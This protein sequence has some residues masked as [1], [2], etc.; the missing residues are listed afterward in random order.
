MTG[1]RYRR[2][3]DDRADLT[4]RLWQP[5]PDE[6]WRALGSGTV[7][8]F[9]DYDGTLVPYAPRP[10]DAGPDEALLALLAELS[11]SPGLAIDIVSGR[12]RPDLERWFGHL[13]MA[14]WAEHAASCRD[15][16]GA[17][18]PRAAPAQTW[19]P[20]VQRVLE[21]FCAGVP[22]S[23]VET[24]DHGLA[25]HYR[26]A[27]VPPEEAHL[28]RLTQALGPLADREGLDVLEGDGVIEV[29]GAGTHKGRAVAARTFPPSA[30]RLVAIGDDRTDEDMFRALPASAISI[31]V[32]VKPSCARFRV[33]GVDDVRALLRQLV[34]RRRDPAAIV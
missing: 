6:A 28:R 26:A 9:V 2:S 20:S 14:L 3:M 4:Q 33:A 34:R 17:W 13:P 21:G 27:S 25:W 5:P 19:R 16:H 30:D 22:G 8:I 1:L 32:G 15:V 29:R 10:E 31:A 24:K 11:Q 7:R 18:S 12:P 23:F